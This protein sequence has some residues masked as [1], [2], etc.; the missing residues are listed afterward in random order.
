VLIAHTLL[1]LAP[2]A[3]C[4]WGPRSCSCWP[5]RSSRFGDGLRWPASLPSPPCSRFRP[6]RRWVRGAPGRSKPRWPP[7]LRE[8][9][10]LGPPRGAEDPPRVALQARAV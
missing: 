2:R 7:R 9:V 4:S 1:A 6:G 5:V 10:R 8:L 3:L